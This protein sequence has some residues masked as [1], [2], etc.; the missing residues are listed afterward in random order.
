MSAVLSSFFLILLK[1]NQLRL[2]FFHN[3]FLTAI[4]RIQMLQYLAHPYELPSKVNP[5]VPHFPPLCSSKLNV[6]VCNLT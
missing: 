3:L 2:E 4:S 1:L 5:P 6:A